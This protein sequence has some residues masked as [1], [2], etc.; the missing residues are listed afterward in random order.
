[1]K[2]K[3]SK[4]YL[5]T[6]ILTL[7]SFF[8]SYSAFSSL[9]NNKECAKKAINNKN[10]NT[11]DS[12]DFDY[13]SDI[14]KGRLYHHEHPLR[15]E[16]KPGQYVRYE[17]E[18]YE[19]KEVHF[20]TPSTHSIN[21]VDFALEIHFVHFDEDGEKLTIAVMVEDKKNKIGNEESYFLNFIA[22][23]IN[24]DKK[25]KPLEISSFD[26]EDM[27]PEWRDFYE[28]SSKVKNADDEKV[29]NWIV[30]KDSIYTNTRT[31]EIINQFLRKNS[32]TN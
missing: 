9:E 23:N 10:L 3:Y 12:L 8:L 4:Q 25:I 18:E 11:S 30:I 7:S 20:H 14:T 27:L 28:Y 2:S 15:I 16:M 21:S 26:L 32:S 29:L 17:G 1:M 5:L 31:L 22:S 6:F 24:S 13:D 19:L